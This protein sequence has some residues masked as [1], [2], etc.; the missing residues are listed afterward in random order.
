MHR[1]K[2]V[3]FS[4]LIQIT[5]LAPHAGAHDVPRDLRPRPDVVRETDRTSSRSAIT[6]AAIRHPNAEC[7]T[8]ASDSRKRRL[9]VVHARTDAQHLDAESIF[10]REERHLEIALRVI[11]FRFAGDESRRVGAE[12]FQSNS[13]IRK[14]RNEET[15]NDRVAA[16]IIAC[17]AENDVGAARLNHRHGVADRADRVRQIVVD[18]DD[19]LPFRFGDAAANEDA[20]VV[21]AL[22][23]DLEFEAGRL[24][25]RADRVD[26][27][28]DIAFKAARAQR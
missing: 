21:A 15:T 7:R 9:D 25:K 22:R 2:V 5:T 4:E 14:A 10:V 3:A 26:G 12:C 24:E 23:H 1:M 6:V 11:D 16:L 27:R 28:R 8:D 13:W 18:D 20:V 19:R 17:R